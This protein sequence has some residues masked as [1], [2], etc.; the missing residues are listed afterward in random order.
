MFSYQTSV[1]DRP[2]YTP[3]QHQ[4]AMADLGRRSPYAVYGQN[5]QDVVKVLGERE[6]SSLDREAMRANVDYSLAQQQSQRD[7]ALS[8]LTQMAKAR[9]DEINLDNQRLQ[10]MVGLAGDLLKGLFN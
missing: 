2:P 5:H 1:E 10:N 9:Q 3:W 4:K 8:G 6:A 7:L